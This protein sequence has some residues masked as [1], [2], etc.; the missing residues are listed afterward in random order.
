MTENAT[1]VPEAGTAAAAG[2]PAQGI[3]TRQ[4]AV[5]VL[6]DG[7]TF[8]GHSYGAVGTTLGEAVFATGMTG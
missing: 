8:R 1:S 6:E 3:R 2:G 5:L 7:T 4:P